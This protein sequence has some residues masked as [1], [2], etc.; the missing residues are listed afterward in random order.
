[1]GIPVAPVADL[2]LCLA[3]HICNV[4]NGYSQ[5]RMKLCANGVTVSPEQQCP[6]VEQQQTVVAGASPP[7]AQ[8]VQPTVIGGAAS[9]PVVQPVQPTVIGGAASA[10]TEASEMSANDRRD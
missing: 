10:P 3:F 2:A 6:K 4:N 1:M 9:A 7:V 8:P 5:Q